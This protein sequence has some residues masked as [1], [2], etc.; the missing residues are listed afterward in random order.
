VEAGAGL[1]EGWKGA[2]RGHVQVTSQADAATEDGEKAAK[3][4]PGSGRRGQE[5]GVGSGGSA[6]PLTP[7]PRA[8]LLQRS[9]GLRGH[10]SFCGPESGR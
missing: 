3:L 7:E 1:A 10:L 9:L 8:Y 6:G 5:V 4:R 2:P